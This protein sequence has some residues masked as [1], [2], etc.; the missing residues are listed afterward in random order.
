MDCDRRRVNEMIVGLGDVEVLAA[1]DITGKLLRVIVRRQIPRPL[2]GV[3]GGPLWSHDERVA[4]L[5]D[6]SVFDIAT[7][8]VWRKCRWRCPAGD[9]GAGTVTEQD[10]EIGPRRRGVDRALL[11]LSGS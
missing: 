4:E 9:S 5:L 6:Q 1:D 10:R 3:C 8:L 2:C 11:D 7:R